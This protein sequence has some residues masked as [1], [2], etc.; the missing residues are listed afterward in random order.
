L[1]EE[2]WAWLTLQPT[3]K[4]F[5][6]EGAL[7]AHTL[8]W[9]NEDEQGYGVEALQQRFLRPKIAGDVGEV[10]AYSEP[11]AS[12]LAKGE[13]RAYPGTDLRL[14]IDRTIQAFVEGELDKGIAEFSAQGGTILV[15]NP[16]TGEIIASASR[17][18]YEPD[19]F[20]GY[21]GVDDEIFLDPAVSVPY[22]PGSVFK[23]LTVAAALDSGKISPD[24]SYYDNG[25]VE[26]GGV[27]I[28]NSD[29]QA[30]GQQNLQGVLDSSLNVG[31]ATFT[32]QFV[33][34]DVYYRY[35]REF[36]LGRR[37]GIDLANE[38]PG[39]VHLPTDF[40]WTDSFLAV[41]TFGQ[42]VTV[43]PLQLLTA[44]SA[45][46]N[47][48]TMMTPYI[49]AER[50]YADGRVVV[51]E[52]RPYGYPISAHTADLVAEMM[53]NTVDAR[54]KN[55]QIPGYRIAGKS[56][57]A[58]I[59]V[60]GGYD[61]VNVITSFVGFGPLPDPELLI[62]V[63]LDRPQ[64]DINL[65]WGTQTAAPIFQRVMARLF[66]LQGIPPSNMAASSQATT[67]P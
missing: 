49:V 56:G 30:H 52:P 22:E 6:P 54:V 48:G 11:L 65:R 26:Y 24:W 18:T 62:L 5:Y 4:R 41:N 55:A 25:S 50:S 7:A 20:A 32:T 57:T 61:P 29:R 40:D 39:Q 15:M 21:A 42:G 47:H 14:T 8:G 64:N 53:A 44:V 12:E 23:V 63:K 28:R 37:T 66:V 58:Q 46:A 19:N 45:L 16:R 9:V 27:V 17:P 3:W 59:P 10:D 38:A 60:P 43:T 67:G 33:G 51:T 35:L 36:G 13:I 31:V 2:K 34:A 1:R